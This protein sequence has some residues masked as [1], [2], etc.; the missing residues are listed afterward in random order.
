[1]SKT[2]EDQELVCGDCGATYVFTAGEQEFYDEKGFTAPKRCGA[3]RQ[4][5]KNR[6]KQQRSR[7]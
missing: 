6:K 5:I 7:Y 1:M 4:A 3:C 2:Y